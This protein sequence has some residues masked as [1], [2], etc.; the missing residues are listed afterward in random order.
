MPAIT[1]G[2]TSVNQWCVRVGIGSYYK[3]FKTRE[4]ADEHAAELE[5]TTIA[6]PRESYDRVMH[7]DS[8]RRVY[9]LAMAD[10]QSRRF[11]VRFRLVRGHVFD[12]FSRA[13]VN[14]ARGCVAALV[15]YNAR[16]L[17]NTN[18]VRESQRL[19]EIQGDLERA[20]NYG[21]PIPVE[22][23]LALETIAN[24]AGFPAPT[25]A[26]A[27]AGEDD[28]DEPLETVADVAA[29]APPETKKPIAGRRKRV[30]RYDDDC[31]DGEH[32]VQ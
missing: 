25:E 9:A 6:V 4:Q 23:Y 8:A 24:A 7:S 15:D 27:R 2:K 1:V 21:E 32:Q 13:I 20:I 19:S 5:A 17:G 30:I 16:H 31:T 3:V 14:N 11:S 10:M 22:T 12:A 26:R 28:T 18:A 29:A